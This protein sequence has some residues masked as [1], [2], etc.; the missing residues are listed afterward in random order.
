MG[1]CG[2]VLL[3]DPLSSLVLPLGKGHSFLSHQLLNLGIE[4]AEET[5]HDSEVATS[6]GDGLVLIL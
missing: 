3:S 6:L 1:T 2:P 5:I 4:A